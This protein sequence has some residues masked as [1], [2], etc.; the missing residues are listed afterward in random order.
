MTSLSTLPE[1]TAGG[2][3][4]RAVTDPS[5]WSGYAAV[6][7]LVL[8]FVIF[9]ILSPDFLTGSNIG[10]VLV[11]ASILVVLAAGQSFPI[12]AGGI[13]LSVGATLPWGA[14]LVGLAA[15]HGWSLPVAILLGIVGG[16]AVGTANGVIIT[17]GR[18]SDFVV[19]LGSLGAMSGVALLLTN[20][21]A[22]PVNSTFLQ[23]LAI[24]GAGPVRWFWLVALV[25]AILCHL[26][27]FHS[28][29]GTHL[30]AIGGNRNAARNMGVRTDRVR[31]AAYAISGLLSGLAGVL[32]VAYTGAGDPSLQT[33]QLLDSIA[34]V[35]LGG[36]SLAGGRASIIGATAGA[37]LLTALLNGFTLLQ[38]SSYYQLVAT[39]LVVIAA[40]A[41]SRFQR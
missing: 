32:L 16:A 4:R 2:R 1:E 8:V 15:S 3:A 12:A 19:T 23:T 37:I 6:V 36:A 29:F 20:G 9:S 25:A 39:G 22:I 7:G 24:G 14:V 38:V 10:N 17:K 35:V 11:A 13:D 28:G 41:L 27:I 30:L 31:I 26:L 5:F 18:I 33:T 21:N 40:A 34:A